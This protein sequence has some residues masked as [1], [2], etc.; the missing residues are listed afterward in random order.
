MVLGFGGPFATNPLTYSTVQTPTRAPS[1]LAEARTR[2]NYDY[3]IIGAGTAGSV[4][5]S[6]LSEDP[7]VSV[8]VLE[9]GDDHRGVLET[10][11]PLTFGKL[12]HTKNDWD[13]YTVPQSKVANREL[14]WPRGRIIGGSSSM[15]AMMHHHCD[16]HDFNEW[17]EKLGCKGWSYKDL[18]PFLRK[19]EKFTPNPNRP[20]IA[21]EHRGDSGVWQTGYSWLTEIGEKGFLGSCEDVGI[22][23]NPDI[24]TPE[25]TLGA[26]RFQ[27]FIDSRGQ[28]SSAATAYLPANVL[29]RKNLTVATSSYVRRVIF[30]VT[31]DTPLALGVEF[32]KERNGTVYEVCARKEVLMCGGTINSAQLL[33][34]SGIGPRKV[35]EQQ[36][37]TVVRESDAVGEN[38]KDHFCTSGIIAKAKPGYTLDYLTNDLKALPALA[39]WMITGGGPLTSNIGEAAAFIRSVEPSI[40][41]PSSNTAKPED[42]GSM[43]IGPDIELIGAPIAFINHGA[44]KAP[45]E[46]D[47]FAIVPIGLRPKSSGTVTIK[48]RDQFDH[49]TIDPRYWSDKDDNDRKVL[50]VGL[51][52]CLELIRAKSFEPYL[53]KVEPNDDEDSPWWPYSSTNIHAITDDQLKKWMS[54]TAFTLYHPVGSVRMGPDSNSSAVDLDCRVHGVRGLRVVDASIFPEQI[55]GHPTAPIIAIAEKMAETIRQQA[56]ASAIQQQKAQL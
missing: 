10:K 3:I 41:L 8:L 53:E 54:R 1:C 22:P 17:A 25:G 15:N 50:L 46:A 36:G 16:K 43:G 35:L 18:A 26:T 49:P 52:V 51:R 27:T 31:Q 6:R 30:D 7:N 44:D 47:T 11:I 38:V 32:Q 4:L 28:R 14:Y 34:L 5:A 37:I 13:Y 42:N 24:N 23:Y 20:A 19:S 45:G 33:Q 12:F 2:K 21:S 55:S 40:S 48:S 56:G 39:R 29:K 9:A